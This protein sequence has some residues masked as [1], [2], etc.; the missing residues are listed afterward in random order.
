MIPLV[1]IV[2]VVGA[3]GLFSAGTETATVFDRWLLDAAIS[4]ADQVR[5]GRG[6]DANAVDLPE[7]ARTMLAYDEV[8][9]T[10]F[11]VSDRGNVLVGSAASRPAAPTVVRRRPR[12]R[13]A[14]RRRAG[15]RGGGAAPCAG[16][17]HVMVL[18]AETMLKRQRS[19][20]VVE[21]LLFPLGLML[22][23]TCSAIYIAVR[24]TVRPLEALAEQWNRQ[25][26][27]S[28][29]PIPEDD[30]PHELSPFATALNDLLCA[31]AASSCASACSPP[32]P[33]TSC[34]RR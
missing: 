18:V 27:A 19:N 5:S 15:A 4:L 23:V 32:R 29:R 8:D 26:H 1:L 21:W 22:V 12:L 28:L 2:A 3:I 17:E 24:R 31:S 10:W 25:A 30:L 11:S 14:L 16:C 9:H 13:R 6:S 34:A 20:R 33:R 7:A